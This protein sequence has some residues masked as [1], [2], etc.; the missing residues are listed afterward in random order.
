VKFSCSFMELS[1]ARV[2]VQT[3]PWLAGS[4]SQEMHR[5]RTR[6][7]LDKCQEQHFDGQR[8]KVQARWGSCDGGS[9][10]CNSK[11]SPESF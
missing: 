11:V 7:F 3:C 5:A 4:P 2:D 8:N 9:L 10:E 6:L 1:S